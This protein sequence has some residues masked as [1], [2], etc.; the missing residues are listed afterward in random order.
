MKELE[1]LEL[2]SENIDDFTDNMPKMGLIFIAFLAPW[3]GHCKH[4]KPEWLKKRN[5]LLTRTQ[6]WISILEMNL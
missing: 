2:D 3:C 1:V 4:F 6:V 5:Q